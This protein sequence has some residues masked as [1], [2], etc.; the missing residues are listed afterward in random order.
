MKKSVWSVPG[1]RHNREFSARS[2]S[3][4]TSVIGLPFAGQIGVPLM[5]ILLVLISG[6][7]DPSLPLWVRVPLTAAAGGAVEPV[8]ASCFIGVLELVCLTSEE[9]AR[10]CEAACCRVVRDVLQNAIRKIAV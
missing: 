6:K 4:S 9:V 2:A 10:S 5:S 8:R 7:E 1:K 3:K